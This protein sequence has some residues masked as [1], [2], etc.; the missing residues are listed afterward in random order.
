MSQAVEMR[1]AESSTVCISA[2]IMVLQTNLTTRKAAVSSWV[3]RERPELSIE[4]SL[5]LNLQHYTCIHMST[6]ELLDR[7]CNNQMYMFSI[8]FTWNAKHIT[9][10]LSIP[11]HFE[12]LQ[13]VTLQFM[14]ISIPVN[15]LKRLEVS[16]SNIAIPIP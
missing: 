11:I 12:T 9:V 6:L 15:I 10:G 16:I 14:L 8:P 3:F 7:I 1:V 2:S 5:I 4:T 13:S